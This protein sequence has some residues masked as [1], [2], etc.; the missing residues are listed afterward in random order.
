MNKFYVK[1][2]SKLTNISVQTLHHYDHIGLLKPSLRLDNGYRVYSEG[3]LL[4]LQQ[5]IAL[6]SFG[7]E[8]S[9]IKLLLGNKQNIVE[10][11]SNQAKVLERKANNLKQAS[12]I[13]KNII[14]EVKDNESIPWKTIIKSIEVFTMTQQL[15]QAWVKDIFNN[16]ELQQYAAFETELKSALGREKKNHANNKWDDLVRQIKNNLHH[17]PNSEIG[18]Q[19]AEKCM[20]I[21]NDLYGKK[22]AHLRT[23]IFEEGYGEGVGLEEAKLSK[24]TVKWLKDA[25]SFYWKTRIYKVLGEN[26]ATLLSNF[27]SLL[28][29]MYGNETARKIMIIEMV[30]DDSVVMD[31]V[32]DLVRTLDHKML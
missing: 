18:F 15:E 2:L 1:D 22:Y 13:L 21:I 31:E 30:L 8:L 25:I 10:R 19:L 27:L 28:D 24:E 20:K 5:I 16:H 4:Q 3:D 12:D 17:D 29:E 32:K 6:K 7:F 14:A 23:K 9:Q 26:Q 11:F